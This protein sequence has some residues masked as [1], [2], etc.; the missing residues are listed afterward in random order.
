MQ[1]KLEAMGNVFMVKAIELDVKLQNRTN[2]K[3]HR[4]LARTGVT[5]MVVKNQWRRL[6]VL[7]SGRFIVLEDQAR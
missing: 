1:V 3:L 4:L 7:G 6:R 5:T 2:A